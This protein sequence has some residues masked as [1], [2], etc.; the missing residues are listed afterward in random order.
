MELSRT[1]GVG[2]CL[3]LLV[4]CWYVLLLTHAEVDVLRY[5]I[6]SDD[7]EPFSDIDVQRLYDVS[8][9]FMRSKSK[10]S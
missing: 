3:E 6:V 9:V 2:L 5:D 8:A 7:Q 1:A 10:P 4:N